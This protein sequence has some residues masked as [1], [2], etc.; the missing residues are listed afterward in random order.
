[1]M[2]VENE[3]PWTE[4]E[5]RAEELIRLLE[6]QSY[7]EEILHRVTDQNSGWRPWK[8]HI[9]SQKKLLRDHITDFATQCIAAQC[10]IDLQAADKYADELVT[11]F[12]SYG[13]NE[14][15]RWLRVLASGCRF[16]S[17]PSL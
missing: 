17:M 12:W 3:L 9:E 5:R 8:Q 11:G 7:A 4:F 6:A 2:S 1:M 16:T 14:I 15:T 10:P 13:N